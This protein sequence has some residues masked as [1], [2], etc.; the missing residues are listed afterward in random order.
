MV[1][2]RSKKMTKTSAK[3]LNLCIENKSLGLLALLEVELAF[4]GN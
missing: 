4:K 3:F 1:K 2:G